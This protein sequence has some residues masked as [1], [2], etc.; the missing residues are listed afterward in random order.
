MATWIVG[1]VHGMYD[2]FQDLLKKPEIKE[3][4]RIILVGDII[5]R[6]PDSYKM[7]KWAMENITPDGKFQMILGNHEDNIIQDYHENIDG[8]YSY[9]EESSISVLKC[10]YGFHEYMKDQGF[11]KVGS[12]K[13]FVE[14]FETLPL[15][16]K[17]MVTDSNGN[18]QKYVIAH[19]WYTPKEE[20]RDT[21]LWYRDISDERTSKTNS[22]FLNDYKSLDG[23]TLIHGHTPIFKENGYPESAVVHF[24]K[25]SINI[26]CGACF[27]DFG[28]RLAA[29][30]LEDQKVIYA[31]GV[32]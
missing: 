32:Y 16:K 7:L 8:R 24:R 30:R 20:E 19:A 23:E 3:E 5:D 10:H 27:A 2:V 6:G 14:W 28:G 29:I 4:D 22:L 26:D 9:T 1:D 31:K 18:E 17:I 11:E 15:Y 13:P 21:F 25:H 12:I